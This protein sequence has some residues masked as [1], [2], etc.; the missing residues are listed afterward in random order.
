MVVHGVIFCRRLGYSRSRVRS[1]SPAHTT[2]RAARLVSIVCLS[3]ERCLFFGEYRAP[4]CVSS[5]ARDSN[6]D[7]FICED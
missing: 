7:G 2:R 1:V 6:S 3:L 5:A 4:V